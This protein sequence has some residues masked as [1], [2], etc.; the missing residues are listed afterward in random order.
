MNSMDE[1]CKLAHISEDGL[2]Q[3][4]VLEHLNGTASLAAGF[5]E[6]FGAAGQAY[7]AGMLHDIGKYSNRSLHCR[8]EGGLFHEAAGGGICS[9]RAP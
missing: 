8:C 5:A 1:T 4:T 2:R 9:G 6:P 3:Q 7:L